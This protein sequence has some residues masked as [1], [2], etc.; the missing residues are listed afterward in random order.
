MRGKDGTMTRHLRAGSWS[1]AWHTPMTSVR[2]FLELMDFPP[3]LRRR[4]GENFGKTPAH[5][6]AK[7]ALITGE[8]SRHYFGPEKALVFAPFQPIATPARGVTI[9][10]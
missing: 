5:Q 1:A 3:H 6:R 9:R 4:L 8:S 10:Y 2:I 7:R